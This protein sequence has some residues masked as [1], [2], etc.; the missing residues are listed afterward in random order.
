MISTRVHCARGVVVWLGV[1]LCSVN[2]AVEII[3]SKMIE[4]TEAICVTFI[5]MDL[6]G[7]S[8]KDF[9]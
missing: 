2:R 5:G 6:I 8:L 4:V 7:F 9:T 3:N 1:M